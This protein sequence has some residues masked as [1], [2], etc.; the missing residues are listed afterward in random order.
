MPQAATQSISGAVLAAQSTFRKVMDATARPGTIQTI[1]EGAAAPAP[2]TG[3]AAAIALTLFDHDTPVWLDA[4][5]ATDAVTQWLRF[6]TG[7]PI[8]T[9]QAQSAFA[10]A[11]DLAALPQLESFALGTPDYPDRSTTLILQVAS[12]SGGEAL[13]LSGPGIRDTAALAPQG[14]PKG[15][16]EQLAANRALFPLGVD[17]LLVAGNDIAALPRTTIVARA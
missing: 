8:V 11:G 13:T 16:V 3:A 17:V 10:V 9:D 5:F 4:A 6:N 12:L 14:L 7:C 1:A 15:F 2:L